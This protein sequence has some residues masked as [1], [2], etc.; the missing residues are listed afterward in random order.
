MVAA[1]LAQPAGAMPAPTVPAAVVPALGQPAHTPLSTPACVVQGALFEPLL[2][3]FVMV[4]NPAA[5]PSAAAGYWSNGQAAPIKG[6]L[7]D[8]STNWLSR[9]GL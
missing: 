3:G 1:G 6:P 2:L 4:G 9:C 5:L 7:G 8:H